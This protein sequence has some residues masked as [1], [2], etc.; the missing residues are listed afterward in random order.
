M[1][2]PGQQLA[3]KESAKITDLWETDVSSH[4]TVNGTGTVMGL[5]TTDRYGSCG[6][7]E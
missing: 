4:S 2:I 1:M 3:G 6:G 5:G 7:F